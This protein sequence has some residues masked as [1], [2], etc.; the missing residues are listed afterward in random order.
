MPAQLV[1]D[2]QAKAPPIILVSDLQSYTF[3]Y[4][5]NDICSITRLNMSRNT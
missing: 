1:Y 5:M 2:V 3:S 4:A